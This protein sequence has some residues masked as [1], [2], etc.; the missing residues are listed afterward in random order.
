MA[1]QVTDEPPL[2]EPRHQAPAARVATGVTHTQPPALRCMKE[3]PLQV[4]AGNCAR[5]AYSS[6]CSCCKIAKLSAGGL[7]VGAPPT[8]DASGGGEAN[9]AVDGG[10]GAGGLGGCGGSSG[11]GP[12]SGGSGDGGPGLGGGE[13]G[14]FGGG[15]LGG[16][17][18]DIAPTIMPGAEG[19][20][21]LGGGGLSGGGSGGLGGGG[22]DGG[23]GGSGG[24]EAHNNQLNGSV[25]RPLWSWRVRRCHRCGTFHKVCKTTEDAQVLQRNHIAKIHKGPCQLVVCETSAIQKQNI[26]R[27]ARVI[28]RINGVAQMQGGQQSRANSC[29]R[30]YAAYSRDC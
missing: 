16:S 8:P 5:S 3:A 7:L 15:G 27:K 9:G 21:G 22:S 29:A 26:I 13:N 12:A 17:G 4:T 25:A 28:Q 30:T 10:G 19:G 11:G 20:G 23:G 24:G 1:S 14:A 6:N 18:G 2:I